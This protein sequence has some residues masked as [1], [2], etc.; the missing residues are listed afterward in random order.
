LSSRTSAKPSSSRSRGRWYSWAAVSLAWQDMLP[1]DFAQGRPCTEGRQ[2][3]RLTTDWLLRGLPFRGSPLVYP[4]ESDREQSLP[5]RTGHGTL[6]RH[7]LAPVPGG[8]PD[9]IHASTAVVLF[10]GSVVTPAP[11]Q[12]Q[13]ISRDVSL[14]FLQIS[15]MPVTGAK[16]HPRKNHSQVLRL[17]VWAQ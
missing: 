14:A 2:V 13:D 3:R 16:N 12:C 6:S 4:G 9:D 15:M 11:P 8:D 7:Q 5:P 1:F 17:V 10:P